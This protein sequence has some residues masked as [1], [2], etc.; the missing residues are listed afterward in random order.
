MSHP[1]NVVNATDWVVE[2]PIAYTLLIWSIRRRCVSG[3][4]RRRLMQACVPTCQLRAPP[5]ERNL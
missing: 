4:A 1:R 3:C 2:R 5:R